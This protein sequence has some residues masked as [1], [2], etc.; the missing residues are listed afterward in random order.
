MEKV[1]FFDLLTILLPGALLTLAIQLFASEFYIPSIHI[2]MSQYF[3]LTIFL[4]SSIFLGS[5]LNY[6]TELILPFLRKIGIHTPI[7]KLYPKINKNLIIND[8]YE[9]MKNEISSVFKDDPSE[10]DKIEGVWSIIYFYLEVNEKNGAPKTYQSFYFF[11]RNFFTLCTF[12]LVPLTVFIF[13]SA[14]SEK[15]IV[16]SI[17]NFIAI[18]LSVFA[19]RWNRMKMVERVF[20]NYYSLKRDDS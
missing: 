18:I 4:G 6:I 15:Y 14:D 20:W 11:F 8:F 12:L 1:P 16:L 5:L 9:K 3:M 13:T 2:E 10:H 7:E 19:S 17:I